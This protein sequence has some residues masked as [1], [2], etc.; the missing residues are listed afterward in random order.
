MSTEGAGV[1]GSGRMAGLTTISLVI[2]GIVQVILGTTISMSVA[3]TANGID[4]IGDGFVSAVVWI[5]LKFFRRPA[6]ERFHFG[7]FKI[8]NL[9]SIAAAAVMITLAIYITFR[10]YNQ[11]VDPH[12]IELPLLGAS[13]AMIAAIIAWVL[14]IKKYLDSRTSN[15][16]SVR[17]DAFNTIK[18]GTASFLAV[19]AL[20]LSSLGYYVADAIVGFIIA[21]IIIT[22]GFAA[23][24]ESS[25]M[26]VDACDGI[27]IQRGLALRLMAE[28]LEDV[29]AA[30][31]VRLRRTGPV[32]QGEMEIAVSPKMSI[33][34]FDLIRSQ[35]QKTAKEQFPEIERLSVASHPHVEG[36]PDFHDQTVDTR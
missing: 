3:L 25:L 7:Y 18:D 14:G 28:S 31:V 11:L 21:G 4:C 32:F 26:L 10:S 17:L 2:L 8:E 5:G 20:I 9:A 33:R 30:R 1:E 16:G 36:R 12:G 13:V 29:Y 27:C 35:I 24:K 34:D 15:M 23:I 6:D 22:I 19:V